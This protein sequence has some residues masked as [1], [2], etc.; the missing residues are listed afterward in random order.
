[1]CDLT[2][3][4]LFAP[5][6]VEDQSF[7]ALLRV[8]DIVRKNRGLLKLHRELKTHKRITIGLE[9]FVPR[10]RINA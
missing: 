9:S 5:M 10:T 8:Y 7:Y 3:E 4:R 1:M 2:L 6:R